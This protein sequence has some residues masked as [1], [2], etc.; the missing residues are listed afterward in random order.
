[1]Y[2]PLIT[3]QTGEFKGLDS[4]KVLI[5]DDEQGVHDVTTLAL[6]RF[7]FDSKP[8]SFYHAYSGDEAREMIRHNPD[9]AVILM[10]VVME[11]DDAGLQTIKYI[12][13]E[14]KNKTVRI[15]IRTGIPGA[16]PEEQTI[17]HY[18]I[19]DYKNKAELTIQKLKTTM[20]ASLRNYQELQTL[21]VQR[22]GLYRVLDATAKLFEHT[23]LEAFF[24]EIGN[25]IARVL[26]QDLNEFVEGRDH[27]YLLAACHQAQDQRYP[28]V[29]SATGPFERI[30]GQRVD[31]A[32]SAEHLMVIGKAITQKKSVIEHDKAVFLFENKHRH[33]GLIYFAG[34]KQLSEI[35]CELMELFGRN[36]SIAYNNPA[37]QT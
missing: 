10:D 31:K 33:Y 9:T 34:L 37:F 22:Q 25:Q 8:I 26:G 13:E 1:M 12:R 19:N 17:A 28:Y 2:T 15:V 11:T 29:I 18:D 23:Q 21:E 27:S 24:S 32:L 36:I 16:A 20:Y 35:H 30:Q 5:A 4:W 6:K 14:L 7:V 3:E